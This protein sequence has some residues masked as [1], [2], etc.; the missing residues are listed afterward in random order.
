MD[1][2]DK[3]KKQLEELQKD[4]NTN[5]SM[6]DN[7]ML[8]IQNKL[9][10]FKKMEE[11]GQKRQRKQFLERSHQDYQ[12]MERLRE[13]NRKANRLHENIETIAQEIKKKE[14][15]QVNNTTNISYGDVKD[16]NITNVVG[17]GNEVNSEFNK[18]FNELIEAINDSNLQN[19]ELIIQE[20]NSKK[21]DSKSFKDYLV[22]L[23]GLSVEASIS[24]L[25]GYFL[26]P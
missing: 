4:F 1:F 15:S 16:S 2:R 3:A 7:K 26:K 10:N 11:E 13:D 22:S 24:T 25:I 19:K 8:H 5:L 23:L 6:E 12:I 21:D 18:K 17:N 14:V 20:L 9:N